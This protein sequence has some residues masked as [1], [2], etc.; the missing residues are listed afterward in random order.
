MLRIRHWWARIGVSVIDQ[1]LNSPA[2]FTCGDLACRRNIA[3]QMRMR[4]RGS[5]NRERFVA[6]RRCEPILPK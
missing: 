2:T 6:A 4:G 3:E 5:G 1:L